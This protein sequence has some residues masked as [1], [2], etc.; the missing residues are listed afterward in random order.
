MFVE[1]TGENL[2]GGSFLP[3]YH[4]PS[5]SISILNKIKIKT[6]E[7]YFRKS[8]TF[9]YFWLICCDENHIERI[10]VAAK[11][12]DHLFHLVSF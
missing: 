1:V 8:V 9:M 4:P 12:I 2:V 3:H 10:P 7:A 5:P 11:D 6:M